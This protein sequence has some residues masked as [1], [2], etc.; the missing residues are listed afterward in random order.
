[1]TCILYKKKQQQR[2][3][4]L[5]LLRFKIKKNLHVHG[6]PQTNRKDRPNITDGLQPTNHDRLTPLEL[7]LLAINMT[8]KL[9][10]QFTRTGLKKL[11]WQQ[12]YTWLWW[13]PLLM[14]S[15]RL[16][17]RT[18]TVLLKTALTQTIRLHDINPW[19]SISLL[20]WNTRTNLLR[21]TSSVCYW[22][23]G[24]EFRGK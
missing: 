1:M 10:N 21:V 12:Q 4:N 11:E 15:K 17:L 18:I 14:L 20:K 5:S 13:W 7:S 22:L 6:T 24:R 16:S 8:A 2:N 23:R 19:V 9:T 3:H